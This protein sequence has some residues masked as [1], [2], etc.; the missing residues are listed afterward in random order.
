MAFKRRDFLGL[1]GKMGAG[2]VFDLY[3]SELDRL[4][5]QAVEGNVRA[6]WLQGVSDSGC[7]DS[8]F[9]RIGPD[10]AD[11]YAGFRKA[12]DFYPTLL[13][14]SSD[15]ALVSLGNAL[16]GRAPLDLLIIEGALA[17]GSFCMIGEL[18]GTLVPFE[19][20]VK[21]LAALAKQ[22]VAVGTCAA[23]GSVSAATPNSTSCRPVSDFVSATP[24]INIPG[25]PAHP[26]GVLL[27]L[28]TLLSGS[29][30]SL[31]DRCR[32]RVFLHEHP[33]GGCPAE[34]S[35]ERQRIAAAPGWPDCHYNLAPAPETGIKLS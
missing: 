15:R 30:P 22:V 19:T 13:K 31:D 27:T 11:A 1:A 28:A 2:A 7:T 21:D 10:L 34:R 23:L 25:C 26:D 9:Q 32:P 8:L 16:A 33:P 12:V 17:S 14:P 4:F 5:A 35:Y 3:G 20:W 24:L 29:V 6:I 18:A